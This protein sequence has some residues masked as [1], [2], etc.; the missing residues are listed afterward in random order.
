MDNTLAKVSIIIPVKKYN[1]NLSE[2]LEHCL[3]LDYE[4]YEIIVLPD[5]EVKSDWDGTVPIKIIPTGNI[6]PSEK[7]DIGIKNSDADVL[8]FLD[9][10][11]YPL[12]DWLKNAIKNFSDSSIAAVG[13][14]AVTS[15]NDNI[16]QKASGFVYS[17]YLA[18]AKFIYRY[19]PCRKRFVDD[20]PSCNFIVK[21]SYME[22]IGGFSS[23]YWPG[24]DTII[25]LK[26][27]KELHKKIVYDPD[28]LVYHHR[29]ELFL[30]HLKQVSNYG[31]HRGFFVKKF[32]QNSLKFS[33]FI[34]SIFVLYLLA[35]FFLSFAPSG[36]AVF[37]EIKVIYILSLMIYFALLFIEGIKN[38]IKYLFLVPSGI[39]LTHLIYGI[40]FIR[41]LLA[42]KL[43]R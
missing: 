19:V 7:R 38:G 23:F 9:D 36:T 34:P 43:V 6:G 39:F 35:G 28:V 13:G 4:N 18:S 27:T 10:D 15:P 5:E 26:I 29:R 8:A 14:P 17:S 33:Y 24:E 37:V 22:K 25:C 40:F 2:C 31:L 41:G 21:K 32:P 16:L 11:T 12:S 42:K 30:P 20:Y 1:D 3:K